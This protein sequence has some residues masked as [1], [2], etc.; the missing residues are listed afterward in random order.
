MLKFYR[1]TEKDHKP[2]QF[3]RTENGRNSFYKP[4]GLI[5]N[6]SVTEPNNRN[7]KVINSF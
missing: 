7:R 4:T 5:T 1:R 6:C 3:E 2:N